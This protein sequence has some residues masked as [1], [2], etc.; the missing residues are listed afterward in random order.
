MRPTCLYMPG[1]PASRNHIDKTAWASV[2]RAPI[3]AEHRQAEHGTPFQL[4]G[5]CSTSVDLD[6][7]PLRLETSSMIAPFAWTSSS[8]ATVDSGSQPRGRRTPAV[9]VNSKSPR[10]E[11]QSTPATKPSDGSAFR[12]STFLSSGSNRT[13]A[14]ATSRC[15]DGRMVESQTLTEASAEPLLVAKLRSTLIF[16]LMT[17]AGILPAAAGKAVGDK[18][19]P[20][21]LRARNSK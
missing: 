14:L 4:A 10:A 5:G 1:L 3:I 9:R 21:C 20:S 13:M 2:G 6:P 18:W 8:T 16:V 19:S 15:S 11:F 17:H 12:I 7:A